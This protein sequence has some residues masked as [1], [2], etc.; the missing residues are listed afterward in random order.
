MR[1]SCTY[2]SARGALSNER[3]YRY[4]RR[5]FLTLLG[6]AAAWPLVA[7]AQRPAV[8][9]IAYLTVL[10]EGSDRGLAAAYRSGLAEQGYVAGRNL[11]IR[12]RYELAQDTERFEA[13]AGELLRDQVSLIYT[14]GAPRFVLAAGSATA[15]TPIVFINGGDPVKTG[16]VAS[17]NRPGRNVTGATF[18]SQELTAKRLELLHEL[19][20]TATSIGYITG[21]G[22][23]ITETTQAAQSLGVRLVVARATKADEIEAA[24]ATLVGDGIGALMVGPEGLFF[25]QA[26]QL[27]ALA[28]RYRLPA[29]YNSRKDVEAG[30]LMSYGGDEA[31]AARIAGLYSGRILK[32]EKPADLPVQQATKVELFINLK[33]AK[34]LGLTVPDT[35]L[36]SADK[37]VE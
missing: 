22:L 7:R 20:P 27:A 4:R 16:L 6:G 18:L 28:A 37:V 13:L 32:G 2:G 17:L 15:T 3:P 24:F 23:L 5:E 25:D 12:Y 26:G 1:E 34:A 29:I 30:G 35:L 8:P 11:E 31:G 14:V 33:T 9:M 19:V 36:V 10:S 21:G